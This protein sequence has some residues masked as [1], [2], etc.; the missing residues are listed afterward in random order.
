MLAVPRV[1]YP[2]PGRCTQGDEVRVWTAP[3]N[4]SPDAPLE[5]LAV[6][7]DGPLA[8]LAVYDPA[9]RPLSV[10]TRSNGGPPWSLYATVFR[11][12]RGS[13]RIEA[14]RAGRVAAC[15][16]VEVGGRN[17]TDGPGDWELATRALY[18][19]WVERL[20]D[21]PPEQ[22]LSFPSLEPVL[23]NPERNFLY[24]YLGRRE[25]ERLPAEPDCADL[26]YFLHAYFAWKMGLPIAYRPCDRGSASRPPRCGAPVIETGFTRSAAAAS[27][28]TDAARRMMDTVHSGSAR[29]ALGNDGSDF[30]PVPLE[31]S[32]LW[33]GT[34]FADPYGHVLVVVKWVPQS[35]T[36]GGLLLAVD[37][38][39]DNSVTRKRFWE[40]TF[41][42]A[43]T[44][45]AGPG[46]KAFRPLEPGRKG[47]LGQSPNGALRGGSG[48][49]P[50]STEQA[51]LR[52]EDF[53]ARIDRMINPRGLA[54]GAA[55]ESTLAAL[56]EQLETRVTAVDNAENYRRQNPRSVIPMPKGAA[57][58]ETT[59]PWEDYS[60]PSRDMRLLIAMNVLAALPD[61]IRRYPELF[62]LSGESPA[63]AAAGVE[64]LHARRAGERFI[65][66]Q[67]S[68]GSAW[69]LSLAD[70]YERKPRLEVA[71]DPNDCPEVRWGAAPN[72]PE[73]ASCTRRAPREQQA[74]ME[75]YRAWFRETRRPSR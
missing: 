16:E 30:Y 45:A 74:R 28:F 7:T 12:G 38:Q 66:Y 26:P 31:R 46:F 2:A 14:Q 51:G 34:V 72:S 70:L 62:V 3:S 4:P 49:P 20:F 55:Y 64:R 73:Y 71:Y 22:S 57:I 56:M 48:L 1:S 9:G 32:A 59:G 35:G 24:N 75:E 29:T 63:S 60:T 65:S 58:F 61:R 67:R 10:R 19:A 11:P 25:D 18:A 52:P 27:V 44:P 47:Q 37:A 13:Y 54:P 50:Y 40:G 68:D 15:R 41:L 39:P 36:R 69:R 8:G 42:F 6:A 33:P 17:T 23:R 53:Y 21:A 5:I 43:E